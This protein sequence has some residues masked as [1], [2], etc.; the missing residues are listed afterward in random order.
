M[1]C[2]VIKKQ[3]NLQICKYTNI[4][5]KDTSFKESFFDLLLFSRGSSRSSCVWNLAVCYQTVI[6][7]AIA[8]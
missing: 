3:Q 5:L 2:P 4:F 8:V 1:V 7:M 6:L